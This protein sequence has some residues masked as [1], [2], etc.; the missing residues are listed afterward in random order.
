MIIV[1]PTKEQGEKSFVSEQLGRA[2]YFYVY[3]TD[4]LSGEVID[5][6]YKN[7]RHGAGV[8]TVEFLLKQNTD[9]LITPR[10][11]EKSLEILLETKIKIYKSNAKIVK[12]NINDFL[13]DEL[14]ELY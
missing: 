5:N 12:E 14:E 13:N 6:S 3:N 10:I 8:K 2:N 1:I 11:G 4:K 9:I 7:E